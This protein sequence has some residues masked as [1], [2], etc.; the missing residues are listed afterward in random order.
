M[1]KV[2]L[3]FQTSLGFLFQWFLV[4]SACTHNLGYILI[5]VGKTWMLQSLSLFL[6][7]RFSSF[8]ELFYLFVCLFVCFETGFLC[9]A[10]AVLEL[11]L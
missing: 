1:F 4:P 2:Y 6:R 5:H 7:L 8:P 11:T 9:E 10:L 3:Y